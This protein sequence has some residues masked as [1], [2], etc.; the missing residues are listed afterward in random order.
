MKPWLTIAEAK[1]GP[2]TLSLRQ[3]GD[4]FMVLVDGRSLMGSRQHGSEEALAQTGCE[5][6]P[7]IS[8]TVL[9]GGLGFGFTLRAALD[10][11][12]P[13]AEVV[14]A[15]LSPA[16]VEWNQG[17]LADL[18]GRPL[19]DPRVVL[20]IAD[21]S[22]VVKT[23]AERFDVILLDVDN[24]PFAISQP[25]NADLYDLV[26]LSYLYRALKPKGRLVVWSAGAD[27]RYEQRLSDAGFAV[28][29]VGTGK[30]RHV[31]FVGD[32]EVKS[33][34][35]AGGGGRG[36]GGRG[37]GSEGGGGSGRRGR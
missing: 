16:M 25:N 21:V 23:K 10:A 11:L 34:G 9:V 28:R 20:E 35:Q 27:K 12:P 7:S 31:L 24:G 32:K 37:R 17:V 5:R 13:H 22:K 18:A 4:E 15:E 2:S 36:G 14:V 3:R 30:G 1:M 19:E 33:R 29:V 8:P 6:L 26:G